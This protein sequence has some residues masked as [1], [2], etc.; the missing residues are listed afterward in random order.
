MGA[1]QIQLAR[2]TEQERVTLLKL[3]ASPIAPDYID[4]VLQLCMCCGVDPAPVRAAHIKR[5]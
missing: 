5:Q 2:L 3:M 1:H 4:T